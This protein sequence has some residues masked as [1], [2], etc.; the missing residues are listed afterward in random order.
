MVFGN[1]INLGT[2]S[3]M[4]FYT[5]REVRLTNLFALIAFTG[6]VAGIMTVFI[7][8]A[9]YPTLIAMFSV[10]TALAVLI[11]NFKGLNEAATYTFISTTNTSIFIINEQYITAV[12]NYLYYFP[13]IFCVALVHNPTKSKLNKFNRYSRG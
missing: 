13:L 8:N 9:R 12:G 3:E 4:D 10:F 5:K 1:L 6:S 11:L 2:K 7:V